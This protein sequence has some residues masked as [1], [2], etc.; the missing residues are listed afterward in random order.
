MHKLHNCP[1]YHNIMLTPTWLLMVTLVVIVFLWCGMHASAWQAK[2]SYLKQSDRIVCC[3][4][5]CLRVC[6]CLPVC[7]VHY[8]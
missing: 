7:V 8:V 4:C 5:V 2:S 1:M 3:V 6:A